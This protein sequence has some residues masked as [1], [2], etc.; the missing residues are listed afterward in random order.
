MLLSRLKMRYFFLCGTGVH[1]LY[2]QLLRSWT[3]IRRLQLNSVS[4]MFQLHFTAVHPQ[5]SFTEVTPHSSIKHLLISVF[6]NC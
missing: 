1:M 5:L 6:F 2:S 3:A 4:C